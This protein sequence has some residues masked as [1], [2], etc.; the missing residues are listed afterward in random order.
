MTA[1]APLTVSNGLTVSV[2]AAAIDSFAGSSSTVRR[3]L[4]VR[5]RS[6]A[7]SWRC[8]GPGSAPCVSSGRAWWL[9]AAPGSAGRLGTPRGREAGPSGAQLL[10]RVLNPPLRSHR[11]ACL[12]TLLSTR[13][14]PAIYHP[15]VDAHVSAPELQPLRHQEP[16]PVAAGRRARG[17]LAH[18]SHRSVVRPVA[19]CRAR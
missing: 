1:C 13:P 4:L 6:D 14:C 11:C 2:S 8:P 12:R 10:P 7:P 19:R 15:R 16:D 9:W 3:A 17:G 18:R 5:A